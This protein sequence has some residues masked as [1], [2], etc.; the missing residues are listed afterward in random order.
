MRKELEIIEKIEAYLEGRLSPDENRQFETQLTNDPGLQ[1]EVELQRQL[2]MGIDRATLKQQVRSAKKSYYLRRNIFRW[3]LGG[4]VAAAVITA[5][6]YSMGPRHKHID[7]PQKLSRDTTLPLQSYNIDPSRDSVIETTK[8][9]VMA[10]PAHAFLDEQG[11][12][13]TGPI[14]LVIKE[15]LDPADIMKAGLSTRSGNEVLSTGGMFF[16]DARQGDQALHIDS[17]KPIVA[18][19]PT[20]NKKQD[21]QLYKGR[22]TSNGTIDWVDPVPLEHNLVTVDIESLDFYPPHYLDSV[23][24]WGYDSRDKHFTDSLYYSFAG[25]DQ[26]EGH[27]RAKEDSLSDT[28]VGTDTFLYH[29]HQCAINPAK[30]KTIWSPAFQNTILAT[31]EFEERLHFMHQILG[32]AYLDQ[33]V[34]HLD[35]PLYRID[36]LVAIHAGESSGTFLYF[37]ARHDGKVNIGASQFK[38]LS[39]FYR[40]RSKAFA[41]AIARTQQEFWDKQNKL[42]DSAYNRIARHESDAYSREQQNFQKEFEINMKDA[43]RQLGIVETVNW[44]PPSVYTASITGTGWYNVDKAVYAS[45]TTRT[46]LN[47]TDTS[48]GK[49]ATIHYTPATFHIAGWGSYDKVNVYL[50][51]DQLSSFLLV[52]DSNGIYTENLNELMKYD[53]VCIGYKDGRTSYFHQSRIKAKDYSNIQLQPISGEELTRELIKAGSTTQAADLVKEDSFFRLDV[54]DQKRRKHMEDIRNLHTKM[55]WF[56]FPCIYQDYFFQHYHDRNDPQQSPGL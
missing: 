10:I 33:Y 16:L 4:I 44:S 8:G 46:T 18:Q 21:M 13:A 12:T 6:L 48:T 9:I 25:S 37:A 32:D 41:E 55:M 11:R 35:W 54:P 15:A 27:R 51:P 49:K 40:V 36:S 42:D 50:L 52:G 34:D 45:T 47:Y 5:L 53:L 56:L 28:F 23:S 14:Q 29:P 43:C 7:T 2:M 17:T 26:L 1:K 22:V 31:R 24:R 39:A 3:G 38:Q 19:I 20:A 30:I